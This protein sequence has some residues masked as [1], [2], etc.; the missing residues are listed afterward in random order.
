ML[1]LSNDIFDDK[2]KN[3]SLIFF[4]SLFYIYVTIIL[5]KILGLLSYL[6]TFISI[7]YWNYAL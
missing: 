2:K 7:K 5:F 6:I 3:C 4:S 1:Y